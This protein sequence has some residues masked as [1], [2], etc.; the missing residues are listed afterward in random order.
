MFH[1]LVSILGEICHIQ[2]RGIQCHSAF[3]IITF[4][5]QNNS[6]QSPCHGVSG[7]DRYHL[8]L[9]IGSLITLNSTSSIMA[10][11]LFLSMNGL[12]QYLDLHLAHDLGGSLDI[13]AFMKLPHLHEYRMPEFRLLAVS[14]ITTRMH[15]SKI[16]TTKIRKEQVADHFLFRAIFSYSDQLMERVNA[17]KKKSKY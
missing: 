17:R 9:L 1:Q 4:T 16:W 2:G 12:F 13:Y 8:V 11:L 10:Y 6:F 14:L 7:I 3:D 15:V 5:Q